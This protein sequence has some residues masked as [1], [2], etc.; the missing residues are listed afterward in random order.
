MKAFRLLHCKRSG[1]KFYT[2][3]CTKQL[4]RY[5][6]KHRCLTFLY[7][8]FIAARSLKNFICFLNV[9][10][11]YVISCASMQNLYRVMNN[12]SVCQYHAYEDYSILVRK[13]TLF[14]KQKGK[15]TIRDLK[16]SHNDH[17]VTNIPLLIIYAIY[18][19]VVHPFPHWP[20]TRRLSSAI[21]LIC[22]Y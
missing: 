11:W 16:I 10:S 6:Y 15:K 13:D 8:L 19:Y 2:F 4:L 1:V 14:Q 7:R 17:T 3:L 18:T 22:S 5:V 21:C 20:Q 12:G 9:I